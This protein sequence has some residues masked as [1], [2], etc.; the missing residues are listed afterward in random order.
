MKCHNYLSVA[1]SELSVGGIVDLWQR[2]EQPNAASID[3]PKAT[4]GW[5]DWN[6]GNGR[7]SARVPKHIFV[8]FQW[9]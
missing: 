1:D 5:D 2:F 8:I 6:L 4:K 3:W 9:N 7:G